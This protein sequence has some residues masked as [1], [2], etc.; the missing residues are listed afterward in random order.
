M[1]GLSRM[2]CKLSA[3]CLS[4]KF[5]EGNNIPVDFFEGNYEKICWNHEHND[6]IIKGEIF[7]YYWHLMGGGLYEKDNGTVSSSIAY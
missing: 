2:G 1:A 4:E 3:A 6:R 7:S 5:Y